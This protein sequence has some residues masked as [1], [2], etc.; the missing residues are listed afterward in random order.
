M[1]TLARVTKL[2]RQ[3]TGLRY[4]PG[5]VSKVLRSLGFSCQRPSRR[6][7]ERDEEN[8]AR[9]KRVEWPNIKKKPAGKLAPSSSS[10]KAG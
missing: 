9:W 8:I 1:W 10:T 7:I 2:I 4:H 5:H 3:R 6:A